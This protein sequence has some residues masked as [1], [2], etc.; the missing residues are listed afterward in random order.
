[1]IQSGWKNIPQGLNRLRK[2]AP[3]VELNQQGL[4]PDVDS[5]A[6]AARVNSCPD[7]NHFTDGVFPQPVSAR[8]KSCPCYK[9]RHQWGF[10][11]AC[12]GVFLIKQ[13]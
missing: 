13:A 10:S 4:K 5:A 3:S 12:Q 9:A 6:F 7:T 2:K 11:A 8:L 1:M